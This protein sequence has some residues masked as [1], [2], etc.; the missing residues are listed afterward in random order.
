MVLLVW[1]YWV[2]EGRVHLRGDDSPDKGE[3]V[4]DDAVDLRDAAKS[5]GILD[6]IAVFVA[7]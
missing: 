1:A 3:G 5:V 6:S 2:V 7:L 4:V